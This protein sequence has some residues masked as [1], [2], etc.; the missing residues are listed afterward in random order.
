MSQALPHRRAPARALPR[1]PSVRVSRRAVPTRTLAV[2]GDLLLEVAI[3]AARPVEVGTDVPGTIRLRRGGSAANTAL[4]FARLGGR[5]VFIGAVGRDATGR[6]LVAELRAGGV[7]VHS[8]RVPLPTARLAAY[9]A[10]DGERSFVTERAAADHLS[11]ADIRAEWLRGCHALHVPGYSLYHHPVRDAA[12]AAVGLARERGAL[13]SVDLSS[14]V[15]LLTAGRPAVTALL[16]QLRPDL[17]LA[18]VA[19]V[20]ALLGRAE[21]GTLL[22]L[23][24]VVVIKEGA[25]GCRVLWR[26]PGTSVQQLAVATTPVP[27]ADT[28][29]AGDAFAA[30]FLWS[31]LARVG[32]GSRSAGELRRAA[33]S[34][35]RAA[36]DVLRRPRPELQL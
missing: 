17:L 14:R 25:S 1:L 4:A 12:L 13:V 20:A 31:L 9:V 19:E 26:G 16:A 6:R 34:G 36:A 24:E 15:P 32:P 28:T 11:A 2:L 5:A 27:A 10:P 29:G 30:G 21:P 7:T 3:R 18:N 23:A 8:V 33:L 22:A 35:H